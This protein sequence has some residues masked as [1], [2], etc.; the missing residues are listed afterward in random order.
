MENNKIDGLAEVDLLWVYLGSLVSADTLISLESCE[1]CMEILEDLKMDFPTSKLK[2][3]DNVKK[4]LDDA[5]Q[6]IKREV[7]LFR[8]VSL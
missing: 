7:E 4:F 8:K 6:I 1:K 2:N 5:E 3:D